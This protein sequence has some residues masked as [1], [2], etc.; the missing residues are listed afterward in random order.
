VKKY[1][2]M[3]LLDS[4]HATAHWNERIEEITGILKRHGCQIIRL[5]KWDDRRLAYPL[6]RSKR[7]TYILCY[8]T[9]P[10][11]ANAK[12]ERDVQLSENLLRLL[13][14]RRDKMDEQQMLSQKV[15]SGEDNVIGRLP[16][17]EPVP[18][19]EP[20]AVKASAADA[21]PKTGPASGAEPASGAGPASGSGPASGAGAKPGDAGSPAAEKEN[22]SAGAGDAT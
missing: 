9:A 11:D 1:E 21:A 7:G 16:D 4:G 18:E 10:S 8:Y 20:A 13:I 12:I 14:V 5:V 2:A 6:Q 17:P 22:H 15:P 3:F 19:P